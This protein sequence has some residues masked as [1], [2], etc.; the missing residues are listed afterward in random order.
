MVARAGNEPLRSRSV[1]CPRSSHLGQAFDPRRAQRWGHRR[2]RAKPTARLDF[3]K[4]PSDRLVRHAFAR[5]V[6]R[7]H[8]EVQGEH[9]YQV[10][11][12]GVLVHN[13]Y[14]TVKAANAIIVH[15]SIGFFNDRDVCSVNASELVPRSSN[16]TRALGPQRKLW[17]G[18]SQ[19][20]NERFPS[21]FRVVADT[22]CTRFEITAMK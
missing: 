16:S 10:G 19:I 13:A 1:A 6:A 7:L 11:E 14:C 9:V 8:V 17:L 18:K 5:R 20:L 22:Q 15:A 12:I 4:R 3:G 21:R 2:C